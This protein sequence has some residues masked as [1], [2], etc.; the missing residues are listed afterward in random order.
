ML[1]TTFLNSKRLAVIGIRERI[2]FLTWQEALFAVVGGIAL[3][4]VAQ[5][6]G[7][8]FHLVWPVPMS[9]SIITAL[10]RTIIL[11]VILRRVDRFGALTIAGIA[12]VSTKL[13]A[14]FIGYWPMS[15]IVPLLA[16]IA[17][18]FIWQYFRRQPSRRF[19]MIL[20]GGWLCAARFLLALTFWALLMRPASQISPH[21][22]LT[23]AGIAV[24][25]V[26]S[27]MTAGL[28]VG[29]PVRSEKDSK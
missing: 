1:P 17:G 20:T 9:G 10:P 6:L 24:I 14:G 13:A 7:R 11:L 4:G 3:A 19:S 12:E 23:F 16:G 15:I 21:P 2:N 8:S 26:V 18:D 29:K 25:N 22:V 5:F 28:L 27:G